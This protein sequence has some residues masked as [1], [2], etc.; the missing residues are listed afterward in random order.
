M[1]NHEVAGDGEP[2]LLLHSGVCDMRMWDP[3][4]RACGAEHQVL[5][6]DLRGYGGSPV[7]A[8]RWV[9][10]DDVAELLDHLGID[11][12]RVVGS[13]YGGRVALELAAGRPKRVTG[14][15]LLCPAFRGLPLTPTAARFDAEETALL[16]RGD[17]SG[18]VELNVRTWLGPAADD[19]TRERVHMMQ[20]QAFEMQLAAGDVPGPQMADVNPARIDVPAV[21]VSGGHDMDHFQAIARHLAR[22]MPRGQLL[23]LPSTGHLPSLERLG[24]IT[25]ALL[26]L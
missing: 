5:R 6:C 18:A 17:I 1:L 2:L 21:V 13:S 23:E 4:W 8:E 9:D 15:F 19:A 25:A 24:E 3:Q 22:T 26:A 7:P 11:R 10:A 16:E 20:R 12:A 14:L